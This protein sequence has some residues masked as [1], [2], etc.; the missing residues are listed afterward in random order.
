MVGMRMRGTNLPSEPHVAG[1]RVG[2]LSLPPMRYPNAYVWFVFVSSMDIILTWFILYLLE[3]RE[4]NP[5]AE[6][7]I[8]NFGLP[9][10][11]GFK[12]AIMLFVIVMCEIVGREKD[13]TG[14]MLSRI[15]V[16]ISSVPVVWSTLLI[17]P[18]MMSGGFLT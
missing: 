12:F 3:G 15:A 8:A 2:L 17:T 10:A 14:R 6:A 4:V 1:D 11:I 5:I 18:M 7:V 13:E 16:I 9:G